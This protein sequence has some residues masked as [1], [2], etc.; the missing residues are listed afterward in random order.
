MAASSPADPFNPIEAK[1]LLTCSL[2]PDVYES[3]KALGLRSARAGVA[4]AAMT[5]I[6]LRIRILKVLSCGLCRVGFGCFQFRE[7]LRSALAVLYKLG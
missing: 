6:M 5:A 1:S 2:M 3:T 4:V 7:P